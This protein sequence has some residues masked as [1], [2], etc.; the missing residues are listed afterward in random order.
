ME[1]KAELYEKLGGADDLARAEEVVQGLIRRSPDQWSYYV[2]L[3]GLLD[4]RH[5]KWLK[6]AHMT[7]LVSPVVDGKALVFFCGQGRK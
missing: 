5:G 4:K 3:L 6:R 7:V 1:L 2:T